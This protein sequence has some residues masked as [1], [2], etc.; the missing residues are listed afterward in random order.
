M[1]APVAVER[2]MPTLDELAFACLA[3]ATVLLYGL[4]IP[5]ELLYRFAP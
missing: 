4:V 2:I 1:S 5:A 3:A